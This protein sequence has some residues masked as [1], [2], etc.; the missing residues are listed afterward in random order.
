M[1]SLSLTLSTDVNHTAVVH[2]DLYSCRRRHVGPV[3]CC[4]DRCCMKL[5][6]EGGADDASHLE[7]A[8][9][10]YIETGALNNPL[11]LLPAAMPSLRTDSPEKKRKLRFP[12]HVCSLRCRI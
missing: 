1:A 6:F 9:K 2:A 11:L 12:I 8:R 5:R 7:I 3:A 10:P 4:T